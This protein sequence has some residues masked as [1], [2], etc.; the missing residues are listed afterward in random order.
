MRRLLILLLFAGGR[1]LAQSPDQLFE[2]A[3]ELYKDGKFSEAR[4]VYEQVR[5]G[6]FESGALYYNLGNAYFKLGN[7][8][9]AIVNY[10]RARRILPEDE[11][12]A[13]NLRLS[14]LLITDRIEPAPRL[15]VWDYW[16]TVKAMANTST[17]TWMGSFSFAVLFAFLS[18]FVLSGS[19]AV[20]RLA[21][22]CAVISAV[23]WMMLVTILVSKISDQERTDIAIVS[24]QVANVKNAPDP[25]STDAFVL[26]GGTKVYIT[27]HVSEWIK[28][29]LLDGKVGWM[30]R[31]GVE[32]I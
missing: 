1:M 8:P 18:L 26:H 9:G 16:D 25:K 31:T 21:L 29:R 24:T 11:D 4:D 15:F 20:K 10:E 2:Q 30:M 23:S 5:A 7:L 27:E 14:T 28:V 19:Y 12:L 17:I 3:N 32:T 6:G 13:H 22:V